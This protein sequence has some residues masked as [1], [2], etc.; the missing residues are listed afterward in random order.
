MNIINLTPHK[1]SIA[2]EAGNIIRE[3][4]PSGRLARTNSTQTVARVIDGIPVV[5]T[6]LGEISDLP[7]P[8][9]DTVFVVS[10][11]VAQAVADFRIHDDVVAPDTGPT[12]IR[13]PEGR[14]VAVRRF[15]V[16]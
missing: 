9:R 13:D 4:E 16:F 8:E 6:V 3:I 11:L 10:T 7:Q 2:D 1:I 5:K 12:C 14:I 15:Q